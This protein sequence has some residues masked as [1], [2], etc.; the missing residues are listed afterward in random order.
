MYTVDPPGAALSTEDGRALLQARVAQFGRIGAMLA[1]VFWFIAVG[2]YFLWHLPTAWAPITAE[3]ASASVGFSTWM[4]ARRG[5]R[6]STV[7]LVVDVAATLV[8]CLV[9]TIMGWMLPLFARPE[10]LQMLCVTDV[11]VLRA[12]MVPS[13][14]RRTALVGVAATLFVVASTFFLYHGRKVHPDAP[15]AVVYTVMSAILALGTIIVTTLTSR[16]IFGL[17]QRVREAARVGQYTLL[18]KIGEGGMGIVYKASHAMLRRPTA[19][20]LLAPNRAGPQDLTRFER[21]VQLTSVLNHPNTVHIYDYGR[22]AEGVLYYAM[23]YLDGIDLETLVSIDGPQ[24]PARVIH[25]LRQVSGAL[26][27]AHG[28]GLIHRDVK[29][30][31]ILLTSRRGMGDVAKVVD[32]GLVRSLDTNA[33]VSRST[34]EQVVGTPLYMSPEAISTPNNL[35]GRSDLYALGAVGYFLLAGEPPFRGRTMVEVCGQHLHTIPEPPSERTGRVG[36]PA[37]EALILRCLQKKRDDRPSDAQALACDL[38]ECT[39]VPAW[40]V[41]R[42]QSWWA[43]SHEKVAVGRAQSTAPVALADLAPRGT[44]AVD[45][46][47]RGEH[48]LGEPA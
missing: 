21:E 11:L 16:T 43:E 26:D 28:I 39:D 37:L 22:T 44:V 14:T 48:L 1:L 15:D 42:A 6:S 41:E 30:G 18:E 4:F 46:R 40:T 12:F 5:A 35:D 36:S 45:L 47:E 27:E 13:T 32:F 29:P 23:E 20:K 9:F 34:I 7:L 8:Q 31:N 10:L 3:M 17:R 33:D 2:M 38:A 24:D 19:I 25:I